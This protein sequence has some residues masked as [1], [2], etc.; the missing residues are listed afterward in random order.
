MKEALVSDIMVPVEEYPC[1]PETL[2]L[3][4]AVEEMAVQILRRKQA[5]LPR[6]VLVFDDDFSQLRGVLRRRDIM[7]GLEPRF[8][9]SGSLDYRRKFFDVGV[10]SGLSEL[11]HDRITAHMRKRSERLVRQFMTP[12]KATIAHDAYI[13]TAMCEMVDHN[14]SLLPVI[15]D[16]KVIGVVRSVDVLSEIALI[17][18]P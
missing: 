9:V 2:T 8:L 14:A 6:V 10:D 7:R 13:T 15:K 5:S 3:G 18:S 16:D 11:T 17:I 12:I 1:I 4:D